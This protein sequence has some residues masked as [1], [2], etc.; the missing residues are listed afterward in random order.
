M[1]QNPKENNYAYTTASITPS[2][3]QVFYLSVRDTIII[4]EVTMPKK[5]KPRKPKSP[6]GY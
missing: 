2:Q 1:P 4:R 5:K 6:P 3:D